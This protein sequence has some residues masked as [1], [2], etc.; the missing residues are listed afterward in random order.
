M[1]RIMKKLLLVLSLLCIP[2]S[3]LMAFV[4]LP[5]YTLSYKV[6]YKG[7]GLGK[8]IIHVKNQNQRV[9]V[10][11]E[12][13]PNAAASLVPN[14]RVAEI[15]EYKVTE[16]GLQ[17]VKVT[18]KKGHNLAKVTTADVE[19]GAKFFRFND[20]K[21][22][23]LK[24]TAEID[25][26]TFPFLSLLGLPN[27]DA[28]D[29]PEEEI[30]SKPSHQYVYENPVPARVKVP[31]GEFDAIKMVKNRKDGHKTITVWTTQT[32]PHYPLK[33]E[34]TRNGKRDT[35]ISLLSMEL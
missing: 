4:G 8:L 7:A 20:G 22:I 11:A 2:A 24:P 32:S 30:S 9:I 31:S 14:A 29:I 12:T 26:F 28:M 6:Q 18:E 3:Q 15:I 17:L 35:T 16:T 21:A 23:H 27:T 5:A 19:P 25:S 1:P 33:V 34:I 13:A 10:T